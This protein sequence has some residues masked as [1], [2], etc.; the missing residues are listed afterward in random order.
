MTYLFYHGKLVPR[1]HL[2]PF[3]PP[4]TP[5]S[6]N[7]QPVV[8]M[9]CSC[10]VLFQIPQFCEIIRYLSFSDLFV[11]AQCECGVVLMNQPDPTSRHTR[12]KNTTL[13]SICQPLNLKVV[14]PKRRKL[15]PH[16]WPRC[17][18]NPRW[19]RENQ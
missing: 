16:C 10:L 4:S 19:V 14:P 9:S 13:G 11:P 6:G 5:A 15:S 18:R 2:C 8:S 17:Y 12:T 1:A 3:C 7:D